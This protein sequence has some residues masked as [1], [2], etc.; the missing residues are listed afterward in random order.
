MTVVFYNMLLIKIRV[1][2]YYSHNNIPNEDIIII[3]VRDL[4][5]LIALCVMLG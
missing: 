2:I 5:I 4:C 1:Q 3:L